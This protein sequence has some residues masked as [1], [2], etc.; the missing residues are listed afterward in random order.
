MKHWV[1][2]IPQVFSGE[3]GENEVHAGIGPL[4]DHVAV[5]DGHSQ[6]FVVQSS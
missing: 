5:V 3:E 6:F 2:S 1:A 4:I